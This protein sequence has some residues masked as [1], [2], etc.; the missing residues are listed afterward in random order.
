MTNDIWTWMHL[1]AEGPDEYE[2]GLIAEARRLVRE[3][4]GG[5]VMVVVAGEDTDLLL[6]GLGD[7]EADG[8]IH[9]QSPYLT[10]YNGELFTQALADLLTRQQPAAMLFAHNP[11]T[12]DL[13]ARLG[14]VFDRPVITRAVDA[15]VSDQGHLRV[16]RPIANGYLFETIEACAQTGALVTFLPNVLPDPRPQEKAQVEIQKI[17]PALNPEDLEIQTVRIIEADPDTLALEEADIVV[18]AGRGAGRDE[19]FETI[20]RLARTIGGSIGGTRPVIDDHLLP[21]ERQIGQT[22]KTVTPRLIINCGISGA[23]EYTSGM[24]KAQQVI[25]INTD[26]RARI[27]RFADLGVVGDVHQV[28]PLLAERIEKMTHETD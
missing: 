25:A 16:V 14:A 23:N 19:S 4:G 21:F 9:L 3:T 6:P 20:Q 7:Y 26:D 5:R 11:H 13:A 15:Q 28:L 12:A 24:E 8:V 27:F 10:D 1:G 17:T 22:G 2:L 18:A